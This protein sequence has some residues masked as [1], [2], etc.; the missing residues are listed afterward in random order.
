MTAIAPRLTIGMPVY[1]GE[2]FLAEALDSLLSQTF[3][4]FELVISDNAS[5]DRTQE[6]CLAYAKGDKRVRYERL[7]Q[8][9]G[10][11]KNY[12]RLFERSTSEYFKWA[13]HDDLCEATYV[14]KC[15]QI[16][17]QDPSVVLCYAQTA[18][19]DARGNFIRNYPDNLDLRFE[20]PHLRF[21]E[22]HKLYRYFHSCNPIFGVI[23]SDTLSQTELFNSVVSTDMILLGELVLLG[24][25][26]EIPEPLFY[27]R[28]HKGASVRAYPEYRDRIA[29]IDPKL[30]G[31]LQLTKWRWL[32]Y[33]IN[34][35]R[36][37][38]MDAREKLLCSLQMAQW[39]VWNFAGLL[40]DLIKIPLWPFLK[41][42]SV[43]RPP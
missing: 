20:K 5:T 14:E 9:L 40:K 27:R 34:S 21:R 31:T 39:I 15:I 10:A 11:V 38:P 43:W 2:R 18:L 1:N 35:V 37:V 22:F 41:L 19:I 16:L 33:Y 24:K 17:D 36:R 25:F 42:V 3:S 8:N 30:K 12:N 4:E 13:A 7:D 26:Y 28:D 6:I 32:S 23:R 29:W